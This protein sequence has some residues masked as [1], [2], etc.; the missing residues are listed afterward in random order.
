MTNA[1]DRRARRT[2]AVAGILGFFFTLASSFG[3]ASQSAPPRLSGSWKRT[4]SGDITAIGAVS[5]GALRKAASQLASFRAAFSTLYPAMRV[6]S[7]VPT[8]IV[9]FPDAQSF[10]RF[11]PRDDRGRPQEYVGGYFSAGPDVNLITVVGGSSEIVFHEYAHYLLFRNFHSLPTWLNEGLAEFHSTFE[12]DWKNGKSLLGRA[13]VHRLRSL[14]HYSFLPLR[15]VVSASPADMEKLWRNPDQIEMFYA[16]SWALVHYLMI[17]RKSNKPSN[18]GEFVRAIERG[19]GADAALKQWFGTDLAQI[20]RE[21]QPYIHAFTYPALAFD[22]VEPAA[23]EVVVE[24]MTEADAR[25][26]QG[27]L[28]LRMRATSDAEKDLRAALAADPSHRAARIS[29]ALV[30]LEH[31]RRA[32][33]MVALQQLSASPASDFAAPY[34]L[35]SSLADEGRHADALAMFDRAVRANAE[36]PH[37]WLGVSV[38]SLALGRDAEAD[39]AMKRVMSLQADP[40]WYRVR[41][42]A[43]LRHRMDS[44]A[45][46]DVHRFIKLAGWE[47]KSAPYAAFVAAIAYWRTQQDDRANTILEDAR[48]VT[49]PKSWTAVVL[50]FMQG[51]LAPEKFLARAKTN[52]ERTEAH[53]YIG[54]KDTIAGRIE[55]ALE[56]FRW[57][58]AEGARNYVEY[59]MVR[60]EL[61]QPASR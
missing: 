58:R 42:Y 61:E 49:S 28:L 50:D 4:S 24:R 38:S 18:F 25:F 39:A 31:G 23:S 43:A 32:E 44:R 54:F 57:V 53:T 11:S 17:G 7:P 55:S 40:D 12:A 2:V 8:R 6:T 15:R 3:T 35:A 48:L 34:Y 60:G 13:P 14:R 1:P 21:L 46:D 16:E 47:N 41:A 59:D 33:G 52:G 56:H 19:T 27:D 5:D 20:E 51:R 37:A 26:I 29:V 36:S 10:H 45:A 9:A 30:D 22:L